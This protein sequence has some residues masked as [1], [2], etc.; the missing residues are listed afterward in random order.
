MESHL[1]VR[2]PKFSREDG[3]CDRDGLSETNCYTQCVLKN[4]NY[5][6]TFDIR[7]IVVGSQIGDHSDVVEASP[8]G[9]VPT[10]S[11]FST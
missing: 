2:L 10:T 9:A 8:V 6:Q 1:N 5:R 11:S 4:K 3:L 7:R